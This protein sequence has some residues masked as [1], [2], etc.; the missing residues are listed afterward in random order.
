MAEGMLRHLAGD[1][2]DVHSAGIVPGELHPLA[3]RA[4]EEIDID[5]SRQRPKA[6][7]PL[8]GR[9]PAFYL[10]VV[11]G[12]DDAPT[13]WPNILARDVWPLADPVAVTGA[14]EERLDAFRRA[15]DELWKRI[16][17][18]LAARGR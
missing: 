7:R 15:R 16:R 9:L 5:I 13:A 14:E 1:R 17:G 2:Y 11:C 3:V 4:M 6:A 10:I 8:L 12:D 18:W